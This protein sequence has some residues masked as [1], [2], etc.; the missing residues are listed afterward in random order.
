MTCTSSHPRREFFLRIVAPFIATVLAGFIT[1][2][3][4]PRI[5]NLLWPASDTY[6][7]VSVEVGDAVQGFPV[8]LRA[9]RV[10]HKPFR[11]RYITTIREVGKSQP[12]CN[13]GMDVPYRPPGRPGTDAVVER[14]L[15]YW[16]EGARPPCMEAL[17]P[18]QFILTTC[19]IMKAGDPFDIEK[20][21][22]ADSNVFTIR[23]RPT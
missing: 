4:W 19:V 23:P 16:T 8:P 20:S 14:D 2:V 15:A 21:T 18:G 1:L 9:V 10:I 17:F 3:L 11:G 13:G 12:I 7:L 6:E 22:C 5:S